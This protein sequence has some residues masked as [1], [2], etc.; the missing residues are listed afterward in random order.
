M[1]NISIL[2]MCKYCLLFS[3]WT[4][5]NYDNTTMNISGNQ[6]MKWIVNDISTQVW[7]DGTEYFIAMVIGLY[8]ALVRSTG[9][10]K[11]MHPILV[12]LPHITKRCKIAHQDR[13][14]FCKYGDN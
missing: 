12:C 4:M 3:L 5:I 10:L 14:L 8:I 9:I 2:D 6:T 1:Q 11:I 13:S 7:S